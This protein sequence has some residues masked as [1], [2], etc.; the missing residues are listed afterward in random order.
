VVDGWLVPLAEATSWVTQGRVEDGPCCVKSSGLRKCP[1]RGRGLVL[2]SS[3]TAWMLL[4]LTAASFG[5]ERGRKKEE[6][7]Q[8][9]EGVEVEKSGQNDGRP[10]GLG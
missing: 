8:G 7:E 3:S 9:G 5:R 1:A 6:G 10:R 2:N 4:R